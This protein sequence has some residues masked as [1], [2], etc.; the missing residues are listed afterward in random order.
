[1]YHAKCWFVDDDTKA[2]IE[3]LIKESGLP[4]Y[5]IAKK[6]GICRDSLGGV[7]SRKN[8]MSEL[9]ARQLGEYFDID[10]RAFKN[11]EKT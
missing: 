5:E 3:K 9:L 4:K 7:L 10:W 1:M 11:Q 2:F 8:R 6:V